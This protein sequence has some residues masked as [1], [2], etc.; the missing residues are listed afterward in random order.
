MS[1]LSFKWSANALLWGE[2]KLSFQNAKANPMSQCGYDQWSML[3]FSR[4]ILQLTYQFEAGQIKGGNFFCI[5]CFMYSNHVKNICF[6]NAK[7]MMSLQ[8]Q[9]KKVKSSTISQSKVQKQQLKLYGGLS[10]TEIID[11]PRQC[12]VK[13]T[14]T[15]TKKDLMDILSY[16]MHGIQRLSALW[17]DYWNHSTEEVNLSHYKILPKESLHNVSNYIKNIYQKP[18]SHMASNERKIVI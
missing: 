7:E 6:S 17:Y 10:K 18:P 3:G 8:N 15:L 13:F 11:E 5:S 1:E 16:E 14:S 9:I 2:D 4:G 12:A